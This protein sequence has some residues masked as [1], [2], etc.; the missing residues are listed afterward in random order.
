MSA[1]TAI[2]PVLPLLPFVNGLAAL[3]TS[4]GSA[5][6]FTMNGAADKIG[7]HFTYD[8][9]NFPDGISFLVSSF[10]STGT[11]DATLETIDAT[12]GFASGTPVTNSASGSVSVTSTGVKTITGLTGTAVLSAG[13]H[14]AIVLSAT[15]GFAGNFAIQYGQG[16]TGFMG[17]PIMATKDSAGAWTKANVGNVGFLFGF[18]TAGGAYFRVPNYAGPVSAVAVQAFSDATNPDERGIR[19]VPEVE[20][21]L[22]GVVV[23]VSQGSTP[24]DAHSITLGVYSAPTTAVSSLTTQAM[25]GDLAGNGQ[26]HV[27]A[28]DAPIN[29]TAGAEYGLVI[30]ATGGTAVNF[31]RYDYPN[32]ADLDAM[33][34]QAN[35]AITR[36]N[37]SGNFTADTDSFYTILPIISKV[38]DGASSGGGANRAALPAGL[39]GLG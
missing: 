32:A 7:L 34:G 27:F 14:Y 24:G 5:S 37:S 10:T 38:H 12:T 22:H 39:S 35:Y 3:S 30:K 9:V 23:Y 8:G 6:T 25:D 11:I 16:T 17:W 36:N 28:L 4:L 2:R 18:K 31:T 1:L 33:F 20:E 26:L 21:T 13:T 15:G 19:Y 29:L